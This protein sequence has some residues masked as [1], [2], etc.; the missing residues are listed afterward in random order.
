MTIPGQNNLTEILV[1]FF[2]CGFVI[3][4]VDSAVFCTVIG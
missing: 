2:A 1:I 4:E 3:S